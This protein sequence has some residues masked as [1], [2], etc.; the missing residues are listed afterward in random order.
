MAKAK[1]HLAPFAKIKAHS[2]YDDTFA[3]PV[4]TSFFILLF[5][6]LNLQQPGHNL[7]IY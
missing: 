1:Q 5:I 3:P 7:L 2:R 6:N 4:T